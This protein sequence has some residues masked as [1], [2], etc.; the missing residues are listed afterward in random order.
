MLFLLCLAH[1][2][3]CYLPQTNSWTWENTRIR[4]FCFSLTF[5]LASVSSLFFIFLFYFFS[6]QCSSSSLWFYWRHGFRLVYFKQ[7]TPTLKTTFLFVWLQMI[8]FG[9]RQQNW[10]DKIERIWCTKR[11][12]KD[13]FKNNNPRLRA[14]ECVEKSPLP[15]K[16]FDATHA[17]NWLVLPQCKETKTKQKANADFS[18]MRF[19]HFFF[20]IYFSSVPPLNLNA[21]V[22][23]YFLIYCNFFCSRF[24]S[25]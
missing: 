21:A 1:Y 3:Y 18:L 20:V 25:L 2:Y 5:S 16:L 9:R 23:G 15:S 7:T 11:Q 22:K 4:C 24:T 6:L 17:L 10:A 8:H 19:F 14:F 12:K 13:N